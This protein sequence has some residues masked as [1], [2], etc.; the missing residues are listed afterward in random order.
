MGIIQKLKHM[1]PKDVDLQRI[2]LGLKRRVSDI[3]HNIVWISNTKSSRQNKENLLQ[4]KDK[5]KGERCVIIGNGPS[6]KKTDLSLIKNE[7]TF[8]LNRIYLLFPQLGFTPTYLASVN[9]YV[10]RQFH[11]EISKLEMPKFINWSFRRYFH[12]LPDYHFIRM[13]YQPRFSRDIT[14]GFWAGGSVTYASM[15]IAYYMGFQQVIL[16]GVDFD[17]EDTGTSNKPIRADKDDASHFAPEYFGKGIVWQLPDFKQTEWAFTMARDAF[18]SEGREIL[19]A[20][21]DGKLQVFKKV[22]LSSILS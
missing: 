14:K 20:T 15:Q 6:L 21:V 7:I 3:P 13:S 19:D 17:Y 16:V 5:H 1:D 11:D 18:A 10:I 2:Y 4:L 12:D 22:D 9:E 8:G